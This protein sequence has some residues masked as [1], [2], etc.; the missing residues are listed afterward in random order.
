[1]NAQKIYLFPSWHDAPNTAT[2][3][4]A[5]LVRMMLRVGEA[6]HLKGPGFLAFTQV[7]ASML[8]HNT[9]TSSGLVNGMTGTA[10]RAILDADIQGRC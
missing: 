9:K 1:M 7:D 4:H 5:F 3:N 6:G 8:L 2:I 10:E